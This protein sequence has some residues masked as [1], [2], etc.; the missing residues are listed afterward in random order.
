NAQDG[1]ETTLTGRVTDNRGDAVNGASVALGV[2]A[3]V[4]AKT[5]KTDRGGRFTMMVP[6]GNYQWRVTATGFS[7]FAQQGSLGTAPHQVNTT[8]EPASISETIIV[9]PTRA[10]LRLQDAPASVSV[11]DAKDLTTAAAQTLDDLL[12]QIPGFSIFRRSSSIV[13][14]PT[15]QGVS[16]RGTGASGSSRTLVLAD[17]VPRN[18]AFGGRIYWDRL[19][20]AAVERIELVRGGSS[21]LYGS[22]ALSGVIHVLTNEP[23]QNVISAESSYGTRETADVTFFGSQKSRGFGA[24]VSGEAFRTDGYFIIAPQI[25]GAADEEASSKHRA[26]TLRLSQDWSARNRIFARGS[27]FDEDRHNGTKLQRND[28]AT[29]SLATGARFHTSDGSNWDVTLFG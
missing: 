18:V 25:R 15:T 21:D 12:R 2:S 8:L 10:E 27:L 7:S 19:A 4:A 17:G 5:A 28:T 1:V 24:S 9:T 20:R 16:L 11:L 23:R 13:A 6:P 14:N 3:D 26:I 22:D 29:E